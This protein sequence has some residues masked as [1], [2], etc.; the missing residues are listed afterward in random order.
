MKGGREG[1]VKKLLLLIS[2]QLKLNCTLTL[3]STVAKKPAWPLP[4]EE[5]SLD[6]CGTDENR[7]S[8]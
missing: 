8:I 6:A 1:V 2:G 4:C 7:P 3:Y 5:K